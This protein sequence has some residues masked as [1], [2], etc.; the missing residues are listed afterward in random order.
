MNAIIDMIMD[1]IICKDCGEFIDGEAPGY[2][3]NCGCIK[4]ELE[5]SNKEQSKDL[6]KNVKKNLFN[7]LKR[8]KG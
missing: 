3:R 5:D 2:E 1:G 8:K 4:E 7:I 6:N